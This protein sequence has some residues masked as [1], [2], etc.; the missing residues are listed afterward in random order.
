ML[1]GKSYIGIICC[2]FLWWLVIKA[3]QWLCSKLIYIALYCL[4]FAFSA[5][6][7]LGI[8]KSILPVQKNWVMR[9]CHGYLLGA[10]CKW[11]AH[12]P[13][14]T[15]AA[16]SYLA[17]LNLRMV[18]LSGA[19]VPGYPNKEAV[20]R[21]CVCV[22]VLHIVLGKWTCL[23]YGFSR[24]RTVGRMS[25]FG[26]GREVG[27]RWAAGSSGSAADTGQ[28]IFRLWPGVR[29][30]RVSWRQHMEASLGA[31]CSK[32]QYTI[33]NVSVT[34]MQALQCMPGVCVE[35]FLLRL[36]CSPLYIN[37]HECT[38]LWGAMAFWKY[39]S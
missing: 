3:T 37:M 16:L 26:L 8:G 36:R 24:N 13:A 14:D 11:F 10:R 19:A 28:E 29:L 31:V 9:C 1:T 34:L 15:N 5:L 17:A 23:N 20:K 18:Y 4:V 22:C 12:A 6:T 25:L 32:M 35:E 7:L 39:A 21:V 2:S 33:H 30:C 27:E 38:S